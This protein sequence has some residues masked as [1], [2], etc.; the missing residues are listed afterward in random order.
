MMR[1]PEVAAAQFNKIQQ[2]YGGQSALPFDKKPI[3][4]S[5]SCQDV[6]LTVRIINLLMAAILSAFSLEARAG[7]NAAL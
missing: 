3:K 6:N 4:N 7:C 2:G 1:S 5:P